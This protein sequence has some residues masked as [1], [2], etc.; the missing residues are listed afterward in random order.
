MYIYFFS[1]VA[2]FLLFIACIN[3][4]NLSTAKFS[5]R[6]KEVGI[7]K[8]VG[9]S[10]SQLIS[11]F[12]SESLVITLVAMILSLTLVEL[13]LPSFNQFTGKDLAIHYL[14]HWYIIPSLL[15]GHPADRISGRNIPRFL[16]VI[17][18]ACRDP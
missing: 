16:P 10:R 12:L 4:V 15:T 9:S 2:I 3:F 6:S 14:S 5:H 18:Q 13:V 1:V 7:K 8:V 17:L 11:Q